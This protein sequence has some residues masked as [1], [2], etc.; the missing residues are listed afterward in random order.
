MC[1]LEFGYVDS[2]AS[3]K[4]AV[5]FPP[6]LA[7]AACRR[8]PDAALLHQPDLRFDHL[9]L[10]LG[11]SARDAVEVKVLWINR[12]LI[13]DLRQLGADVLGPI[14]HL[15][16]LP[17]VAQRLDI[18]HASDKGRAVGVALLADDRA[19]IID[20][21]RLAAPGIDRYCAV[22]VEVIAADVGSHD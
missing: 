18:D 4:C 7:L 13:N 17:V 12:L 9:A 19:A 15:G 6:Y 11:V 22:W 8:L 20:D 10:V 14:G 21:H 3:A 2:L 16:I 5:A 1:L